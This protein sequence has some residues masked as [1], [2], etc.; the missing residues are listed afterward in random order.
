VA[1]ATNGAAGDELTVVSEGNSAGQIGVAGSTIRFGNVP[2]G[3]FAAGTNALT[4][5]VFA[6]NTNATPAAV[7]ALVQRLAFATES[8]TGNSR[9]L[10]LVVADGDGGV[11]EPAFR[12]VVLNHAPEATDD[13]LEV[14]AD[15]SVPIPVEF[16]LENDTDVDGDEIALSAYSGVTANGGRVTL[17]GTTLTYRARA[18]FVGEDLFAYLIDDGRGGEAVGILTF[19]VYEQ[20]KL[21]ISVSAENDDAARMAMGGTPGR[22]YRIDYST[23][24]T[25][26]TPL[27]T[28]T[29]TA[30]GLVEILD[31]EARNQPQRF[32]RAIEQ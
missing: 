32:Y 9:V 22:P 17:S 11:S 27:T 8:N 10:R 19:R 21:V 18:G 20:N 3:T 15:L 14:A 13:F 4:E 29:A 25:T 6:F 24:L 31:I 7:E 26:W 2:I 23:D 16:L 12:T 30:E 1:V 5:L 28:V